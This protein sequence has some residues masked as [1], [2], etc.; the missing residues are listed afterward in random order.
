MFYGVNRNSKLSTRL[1]EQPGK[2]FDRH[3]THFFIVA[4]N[5]IMIFQICFWVL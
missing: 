2:E 5:T 3:D 1:Y 4:V